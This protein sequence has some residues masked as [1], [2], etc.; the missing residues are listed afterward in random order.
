MKGTCLKGRYLLGEVIGKGGMAV[1]Y[2]AYDFRSGRTV[3]VKVLRE[4]YNQD[5]EFVRRFEQEAEAASAI[6]HDN[7]IDIYDVGEQ[8]GTRFIVME[9][10][11]GMTLKSLIK[12]HGALD[13]YSAITIARQICT[14][15]QI[16]HDAHIIHRDIKPQNIL[17][18]RRGVA[19]LADFGIAK[20]SDSQTNTSDGENGVLGSVHYFS[21]EQARGEGASA[22][23]DLYSLGV[24][25]YEMT[26]AC[27]PFQGDTPVAI[28]LQHMEAEPTPP[29]QINPKVTPA[30]NE[31]VLK[32]IRK[33]PEERYQSALEFYD[34][35]SM[36]LVY[37]EG[38]FIRDLSEVN[39]LEKALQGSTKGEERK[40]DHGLK[41]ENKKKLWSVL[42][43]KRLLQIK[44]V[45]AGLSAA[46]VLMLA[47]FFGLRINGGGWT[48]R[49]VEVPSLT[50]Q[51]VEEA[52]ADL[53]KEK[54][55]MK[56]IETR[57]DEVNAPGVI[58][59]QDPAPETQLKAGEAVGVVVSSGPESARLPQ[60]KDMTLEEAQKVL[61]SLGLKLGEVV[62]NL[63]SE[64]ERGTV[65]GQNPKEGTVLPNG[66]SVALTVSDPPLLR[67]APDV[68]GTPL[69]QAKR[70]IE[71][72]GLKLG[73]M[74]TEFATGYEV[75]TVFKQ[76]PEEGTQLREGDAVDVWVVK[77]GEV[78]RCKYQLQLEIKENNSQVNIFVEEGS[79]YLLINE[80]TSDRGTLDI[81]LNLESASAGEKTLIIFV[82][83]EEVKRDTV[84]FVA[85][86]Q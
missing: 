60:L 69:A 40:A 38:G 66:S 53:D 47:T 12:E 50:G 28:A 8:S 75:G 18:D 23:S 20:T 2:K 37:P 64:R 49:K 35:L 31:I 68:V 79:L 16:A 57:F 76:S 55:R 74:R 51:K 71:S 25:L 82:N 26:T 73:E 56:V 14:A 6:S 72:A 61:E 84:T 30:I 7:L 62:R 58:I 13:N 67:Q 1:V 42:E 21:P 59:G 27:L 77:A 17:L 9:Y 81:E 10:V 41:E 63:E 43:A 34:D 3:A 48:Q 78:A 39:A 85:G 29:I 5:A 32:A 22:Q 46:L 86:G 70:E 24:V 36:A 44:W 33:K 54:L 65:I 4:Q 80:T 52:A 83:D 15:L 45:L 19:K 11:D